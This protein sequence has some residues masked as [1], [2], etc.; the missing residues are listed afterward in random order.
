[1]WPGL[2][3]VPGRDTPDGQTDRQTDR[4]PIANTRSTVPASTVLSRVNMIR[5]S[6]SYLHLFEK[7]CFADTEELGSLLPLPTQPDKAMDP[8]RPIHKSVKLRPNS[9]HIVTVQNISSCRALR[10]FMRIKQIYDSQRNVK[11]M[12]A[13]QTDWNPAHL[14]CIG[15]TVCV[16]VNVSVW[17]NSDPD[18]TWPDPVPTPGHGEDTLGT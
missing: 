10:L 6:R 7:S 3:S 13:N 12:H 14:K 16:C 5:C 4:I 18:P 8:T 2:D 9:T 17:P 11:T 1:M 15:V